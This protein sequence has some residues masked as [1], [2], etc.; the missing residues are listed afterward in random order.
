MIFWC[1]VLI[2]F[3][4]TYTST[5]VK[6]WLLIAIVFSLLPLQGF[7][8]LRVGYATNFFI[9]FY[10]GYLLMKHNMTKNMKINVFHCVLGVVTYLLVGILLTEW[11]MEL[12]SSSLILHGLKILLM[13]ASHLIGA[14][15]MIV[16]F[17]GIANF[18]C[19]SL[20]IARHPRFIKLSGY[21]YGVY[22]YQQ[23]ILLLLYFHT[24]IPILLGPVVLPWVACV[25]TICLSL[26][27][28]HL[29]LKT[30]LGRFL[31]G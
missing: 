9:Y 6:V 14:M 25:V 30:R 5:S 27:M 23:F 4:E 17:Y 10:T 18:F 31:I 19:V 11:L 16:A 2:Y 24:D 15:A 22:I 26:F 1:F 20:Y 28:C 13:R 8:P 3:I 29:T 21:C 7:L 12:K